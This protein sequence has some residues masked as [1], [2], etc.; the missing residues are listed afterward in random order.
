MLYACEIWGSCQTGKNGLVFHDSPEDDEKWSCELNMMVYWRQRDSSGMI[1][2]SYKQQ[3]LTAVF[4]GRMD[5]KWREGRK[6]VLDPPRPGQRHPWW[7]GRMVGVVGVSGCWQRQLFQTSPICC[8]VVYAAEGYG[9]I[10]PR[11]VFLSKLL[12]FSKAYLLH[13]QR[14]AARLCFWQM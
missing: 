9:N 13:H 14:E 2:L 5:E 1:H 8:P 10:N 4:T 3:H 12:Y 6:C 7:T 11:L